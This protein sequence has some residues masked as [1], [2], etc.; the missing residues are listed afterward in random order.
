MSENE[1]K[2]KVITGPGIVLNFPNIF[3]PK[4]FAGGNQKYGACLIISKDDK[5]TIT[6]INAAIVSAY[7][8]K[9]QEVAGTALILPPLADLVSPL[10]D[11]DA[12]YPGV[13]AYQNSWYL[14]ATSRYQPGI[15]DLA[16]NDITD[17]KRV[18]PGVVCRASITMYIYHYND[19]YGIGCALNNLQLVRNGKRIFIPQQSTAASD[20]AAF[21]Q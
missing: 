12:D 4:T 18:Y 15:V 5:E 7:E 13:E 21:K 10:K 2:T 20:F 17:P 3:Q 16:L 19:T 9:K 8:A 14:N 1:I 6:A 11:G